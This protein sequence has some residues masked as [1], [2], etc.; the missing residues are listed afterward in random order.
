MAAR[1]LSQDELAFGRAVLLATDALGM[2]A[3]GAFWLRYTRSRE[4]HYFLVTSL[5]D[6]VGP[7]GI[8]LRLNEALAKKLSERETR[9]FMFYIASPNE[10][11]VRNIRARVLTDAHASEPTRVKLALG[12]RRAEA[13][14]YRLAGSMNETEAKL[15]QRRFR[16]RYNELMAA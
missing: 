9:T 3:E 14:V 15:A 16:R 12:S 4:W 7:R 11:L 1:T 5:L 2:S 8:Y 6:S 10:R 13:W